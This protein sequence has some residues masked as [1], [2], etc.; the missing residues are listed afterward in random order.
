MNTASHLSYA[1]ICLFA[2]GILAALTANLRAQAPVTFFQQA[3]AILAD[4]STKGHQKAKGIDMRLGYPKGWK[5]DEGDRPNVV[6]KFISPKGYADGYLGITISNLPEELS[7]FDIK[8]M[9]VGNGPSAILPDGAKQLTRQ[10]TKIEQ[11]D[12]DIR[13]YV[14]Q[15]ERAG[16]KLSLFSHTLVFSI[17]R[18]LV[19]VNMTCGAT[20]EVVDDAALIQRGNLQSG[21]FRLCI[22]TI[23]L[24]SAWSP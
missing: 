4:Y 20:G 12:A 23:V 16:V 1:V 18:K 6:Q 5:A 8:S 17:N 19:V 21:L 22:N 9:F 2:F 11:I 14:L 7:D 10:N 3:N 13:T 24:A 15:T